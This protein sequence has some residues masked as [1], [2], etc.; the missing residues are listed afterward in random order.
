[1]TKRAK[2]IRRKRKKKKDKAI[3]LHKAHQQSRRFG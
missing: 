1:M 2:N 3:A